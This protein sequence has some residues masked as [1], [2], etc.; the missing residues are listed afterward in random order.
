MRE[1]I[2][3]VLVGCKYGGVELE[4]NGEQRSLIVNPL[5]FRASV[6]LNKGSMSGCFLIK[7]REGKEECEQR[8]NRIKS[9]K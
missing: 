6:L 7:R 1:E 4:G 5:N 2:V 8:E 9:L 3:K